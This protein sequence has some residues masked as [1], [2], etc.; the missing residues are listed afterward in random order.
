LLARY[1]AVSKCV[2]CSYTRDS[3]LDYLALRINYLYPTKEL[4]SL[5]STEPLTV[6]V[7]PLLKLSPFSVAV[8][9]PSDSTCCSSGTCALIIVKLEAKKMTA[10][11]VAAISPVA[12]T[13]ETGNDDDDEDIFIMP[14]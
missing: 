7:S 13:N 2:I 4:G 8:T 1:K 5:S 9:Y 11:V 3:T 12:D 14:R 6:T 10:I